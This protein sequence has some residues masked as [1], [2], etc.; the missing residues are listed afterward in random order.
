MIT[1]E[2]AFQARSDLKPYGDNARLLFALELRF[3]LDD[4]H[5]TALNALTDDPDDK[6]C[7]LVYVDRSSALAVVAQ[8]YEARDSTRRAAP[9][10]KATDLNTAASWLL[11]RHLSELPEKLRPAAREFRSA[12]TDNAI[13]RV[14]FWYV[15]NLPES[16]NVKNEL[17][18]VETTI[19]SALHAHFPKSHVDEVAAVEVGINTLEDWY[20]ALD[21]PILVSDEFKIVVSGGYVE[22]GANWS[23]YVTSVPASWLHSVFTAKQSTLFSPNL[24]GYLGSRE[25]DAN[26]N[27]GIKTT[28]E[29]D[30][31]KFWVFNNGI[32]AL[33]HEFNPVKVRRG[34]RL[35]IRGLGIVNG[36]QTAGAIGTLKSPPN[37]SARVQIRFVQCT[38]LETIRDIIKYNNSQNRLQAADFRSNDRIQKRLRDEFKKIPGATYLGGRRGGHD[39]VIRRPPHL[40]PSD[41]CAQALAIF[42]QDPV[43]A[44]NDRSEIWLD[45][46]L[47]SKYFCDQTTAEHIVF[48]YSL[49]RS[50]EALRMGLRAKKDNQLTRSESEQLA[51]L[52]QR[53]GIFLLT[54]AIARCTEVFIGRPVPNL[55][56]LS[57]GKKTSP[58]KAQQYWQPVIESAIPFHAQ[59]QPAIASG[60]NNSAEATRVVNNFCSM[61][62]SVKASNARLFGTFALHVKPN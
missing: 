42:H 59:L 12:L 51:F 35:T 53:G 55:F 36:A 38:D 30:P 19:A 16:H 45:D 14:H 44:Y 61:V 2:A 47:Y 52:R 9:S 3:R 25:S 4:I 41:T 54:A 1:H 62:E 33:V 22:K 27:N 10:K 11:S 13:R 8:A 46:K 32:T 34:T 28:A 40:M 15:H 39:D 24:R 31:G 43:T 29:G 57:F 21:A 56:R 26:I 18:T 58:E 6:Q 7:D 23:A 37:S 17:I 50:V 20:K 60:I 48:V 49:L 5:T